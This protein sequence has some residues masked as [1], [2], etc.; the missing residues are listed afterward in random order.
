MQCKCGYDFLQDKMCKEPRESISYALIDDRDYSRFLSREMKVKTTRGKQKKLRAIA[1]AS[2]FIGALLECPR[3]SRLTMS[4]SVTR[5]GKDEPE[6]VCF[7]KE[8]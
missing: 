7:V 2:T 1:E 3:C 8:D 6:F 5:A 4:K